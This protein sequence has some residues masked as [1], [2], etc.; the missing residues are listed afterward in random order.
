MAL[1]IYVDDV[2][3]TGSCESEI[4]QVKKILAIS[5]FFRLVSVFL[6]ETSCIDTFI[7]H[8]I[9]YRNLLHSGCTC[10]VCLFCF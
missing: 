8:I 2:M 4:V 6:C 7:F 5:T 3:I 9:K 1:I 10:S